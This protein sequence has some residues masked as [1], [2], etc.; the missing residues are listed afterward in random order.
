MHSFFGKFYTSLMVS[1]VVNLLL[2]HQF[3]V[4]SAMQ[5]SVFNYS[6]VWQFHLVKTEKKKMMN[7]LKFNLYETLHV[8][9][10]Q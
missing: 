1:F 7:L 4:P 9:F 3:F 2:V 10:Y 5:F 8:K 6:N